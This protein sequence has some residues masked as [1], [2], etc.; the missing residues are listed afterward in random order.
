LGGVFST[1]RGRR[2]T[3][4][5]RVYGLR[6]LRKR[7]MQR[8]LL[9]VV[10]AIVLPFRVLQLLTFS[11]EIQWGYDL[12]AYWIAGRHVLD[13]LPIYGAAQLAGPYSPQAQFLYLYPPFLAVAIAPLVA[14]VNVDY[15]IANWLWA[16]AGLVVVITASLLLSRRERIG[17]RADR[18][19]VVAAV[20]AF[21]PVVG[22]LVMGNV[23]LLLLGLLTGAWL[24]IRRGGRSGDAI[25]G[26]LVGVAIL[27]KVFPAVLILWFLLRRRWTAAIVASVTIVVLAVATLPVVGVQPW[28]DYPQVLLNLGAPTDT[29]DTLAPSVWLAA[30]FPSAVARTVVIAAVI[31]VVGW[32]ALRKA[33]V[34]SFAV[35]VAC[36]VLAAPALY[37]HYL[38]V[39]VLPILVAIAWVTP[40]WWAVVAYFLMFGG[41]QAA[42][43]DAQ[44]IV[45]RVLPTVGALLV[46]VLLVV[47][48]ATPQEEAAAATP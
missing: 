15:Q 3:D 5:S 22:E 25:G 9:L 27:I 14:F 29:H 24:A 34:V 44:W 43:G 32:T 30:L 16:A 20:L 1:S 46:T 7:R 23:H 11:T 33:E 17:S 36:S 28:L 40:W 48:G 45:N 37:H 47:G 2:V 21:P 42:L 41:E 39:L 8:R 13:G 18:W 26:M 6:L 19:M 12:S 35:A 4:L 38:A 31:L 10:L